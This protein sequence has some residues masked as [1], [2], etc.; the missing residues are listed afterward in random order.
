MKL[1]T[2]EKISEAVPHPNADR[3]TIYKMEG[4][5]WKVISAEKFCVG[6]R[7]V[8]IKTDTV[9]SADVPEYSFLEK[10]KYRVSCIRLRG[11][12]SNGL[13]L[14]LSIMQKY[15]PPTVQKGEDISQYIGVT[16]YVKPETLQSG[17]SAGAFPTHLISKTDEERGESVPEILEQFKDKE[18][19][20][21]VK[22]DGSSCTIINS[23]DGGFIVCSRNQMV[24]ESTNSLYWHPV[25]KYNLR[26]KLPPGYALQG[27]CYG[28]GVQTNPEELK[29][30]DFK[31]FSVWDVPTRT[32]LSYKESIQLCEQIGVP[33]VDVMYHGPFI[34]NDMDELVE[35]AKTAKY[36]NGAA[37]EGLVFRLA[38]PEFCDTIQKE[39]SFKIINYEYKNQ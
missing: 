28:Y 7:V 34:W 37:A 6:D 36:S 25:F 13:I 38:K 23:P 20:I 9:V 10:N 3:L 5:V 4:M 17:D 15:L 31:V 1:A 16:K 33:F 8:Y 21:S 22:V 35:L 27:E 19:Y 11:Q 18:C 12:F 32:L 30:I 39:A 26:E 24:K 14:P 2:I 29:T